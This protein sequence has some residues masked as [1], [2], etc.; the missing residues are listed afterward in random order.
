MA[1]PRTT[2]SGAESRIGSAARVRGRVQGEG[3][4]VVEGHV[5]GNVSLRGHLTVAEG[6][7]LTSDS[8]EAQAVTVGGSLEGEVAAHGPVQLL[9][10]ARV[11]G[12]LRGTAVTI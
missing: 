4:L 7:S 11:R 3:D 8:V 9:A 12:N 2:T 10:T 5:E 1:Q 6:A